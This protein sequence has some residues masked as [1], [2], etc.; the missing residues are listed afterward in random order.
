MNERRNNSRLLCSELIEVV[1]TDAQGAPC[2]RIAN[3][4]DISSNGICLQS[5]ISIPEAAQVTIR[6][7]GGALSGT[8]RYCDYR[9][10]GYLIGVSLEGDSGW[11]AQRLHPQHLVDPSTLEQRTSNCLDESGRASYPDPVI[12]TISNRVQ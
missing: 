9:Q 4:E 6:Y 8:V 2:R 10:F 3:L 1:W 7:Q 5:E 11:D 12:S